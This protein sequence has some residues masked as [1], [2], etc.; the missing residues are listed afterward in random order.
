[1]RTKKGFELREL[2]GE[3]VIVGQGVENID[4]SKIISMNSSA[5]LLW[6]N[7]VG[8][9]FTADDLAKVLIDNYEVEESVAK[10]DAEEIAEEWIKVG[11]VER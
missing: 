2:C 10:A 8:K 4:F 11:I 9:E 3:Q 1:M 6:K 5:A 7:V